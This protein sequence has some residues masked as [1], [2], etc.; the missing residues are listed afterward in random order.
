MITVL[1]VTIKPMFVNMDNELVH[2]PDSAPVTQM[3]VKLLHCIKEDKLCTFEQLYS[4]LMVVAGH[5]PLAFHTHKVV[6]KYI[7]FI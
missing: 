1:K 2:K 6:R 7:T 5:F 4:E 3:M